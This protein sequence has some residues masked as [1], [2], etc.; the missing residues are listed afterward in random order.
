MAD[1][2]R[3]R[4]IAAK[5][6]V[7]LLPALVF[8]AVWQLL[9]SRPSIGFFFST[10]LDV[11]RTVGSLISSGELQ[12]NLAVTGAETIAGFVLGNVVGSAFGIG[13][14]Y[15]ETSAWIAKPYLTILGSVPVFALAPMTILWFGI[16]VGAKVALAF[17]GTVLV[18]AAQ[19]HRGVRLA[20][21]LL[22]RRF[23]VFGA[24]RAVI[25]R[26]LLL[27]SAALWIIGSLRLT[28]GSAL[29][30]AFVGEFIASDRGLGHLIVR[31]SG[32]YDAATVIAGVI[33]LAL[34]ALALD[35]AIDM[36]EARTQIRHGGGSPDTGSGR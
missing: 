32:L 17:L 36:I 12:R 33:S 8:L 14:W 10:P 6:V 25:F 30:G 3:Y 9:G 1:F 5:L 21:P 4:K 29:L 7:Q 23:R 35:A 22:V 11:A 18:A 13:L 20:D 24:S 16:G 2:N 28:I 31:A 27:P 19:A 26:H 34:M 15:S